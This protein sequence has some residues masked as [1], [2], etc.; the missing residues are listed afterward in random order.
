ML[1]KLLSNPGNLLGP[2]IAPVDFSSVMEDGLGRAGPLAVW[3]SLAGQLLWERPIHAFGGWT[4]PCTYGQLCTIQ[5][6]PLGWRRL[7]MVPFSQMALGKGD[8]NLFFLLSLVVMIP[9]PP[10]LE[11]F[12]CVRLSSLG[13]TTSALRHLLRQHFTRVFWISASWQIMVKE[14]IRMCR[15]LTSAFI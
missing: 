13:R 8:E 14:V 7:V 5:C 6:F 1:K 15:V 9:Y 11:W 4:W 3:K 12:W 10:R 2:L